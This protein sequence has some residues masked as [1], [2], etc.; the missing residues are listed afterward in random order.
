MAFEYIHDQAIAD[1]AFKATGETVQELFQS[2]AEAVIEC[3]ADVNT[4]KPEKEIVIEKEEKTIE[5][6]LLE[7]LEDII[8]YKDKDA[9]VFH[10]VTVEVNE[11]K[12]K[13]KA[14]LHGDDIKAEEQDLLHD[15][16]AITMH[17]W[18]VDKTDDGWVANVVLDI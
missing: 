8:Y 13:A 16:K 18:R 10:D 7:L 11:E 6:L 15:V 5:R 14:T 3:L 12:L 17:Y 2:C 1:I 9:M 4:V